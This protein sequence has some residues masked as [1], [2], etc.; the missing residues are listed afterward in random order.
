MSGHE[1]V[2]YAQNWQIHYINYMSRARGF[3]IVELLV[4][5]AI[6]ATMVALLL[7]AVQSA[8][9]SA[10]AC[11]CRDNLRQIGSALLQYES[12]NGHF[13]MGA[14]GRYDRRLSPVRMFGF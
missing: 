14:A 12:T 6:V 4:V 5:F 8:R 10:R 2:V 7:P 11:V 13:P 9:E 1:N 3:S